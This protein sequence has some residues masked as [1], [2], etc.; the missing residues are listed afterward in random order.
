VAGYG[1][2]TAVFLVT[3]GRVG[4]HFGRRRVFAAGLA[5]FVVT[6]AA[7]GL[8]PGPG[9]LVAARLAQGLSAALMS[10]N[11]LSILGVVY[12]GAARV[13]AISVYGMV[14]GLA[15]VSGQLLG[16]LLLSADPAGLGWRVVFW[17]NLPVGLAAL[18]AVR[19]VPES[20]ADRSTRVDLAGVVL[21]TLALLAVLLPL[22]Q[23]R[24]LG[25]PPWSWGCLGA[26]P[27]LLW[28]FARY[29][30]RLAGRGGAPLLDPGVFASASLRAGLG[31]QLVFWCQQ[32]ACY[33]FLA[34][35]LQQ[36]R[37]EGA[38]ESGAVFTVLAA[39]Y[40]VT[41]LR[42][43]SLTIRFGRRVILIGSLVAAA[44][45]FLLLGAVGQAGTGGPVALLFPGLFLVGAGQGL[46]ITP[47]TTTV[48]SHVG[49]QTAGSV[50]GTL[51]T[52]QQAGNALGVAVVGVV[53]FGAA[54]HGY[55]SSFGRSVLAM[56]LLLLAVA[57]LTRLLPRG[58]VP[59]RQAGPSQAGMTRES[60]A[61]GGAG[62]S[63]DR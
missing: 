18:A 37:G 9:I 6:S 41:S 8:A 60:P 27:V 31:T 43:P 33:L 10:P 17:I 35:Y 40:L 58:A 48:L 38:L 19:L 36:G 63:G 44:G 52:M 59:V 12:T 30:R 5:L 22:V 25:W 26:S 53:F 20:R 39:G 29:E 23:G 51:S 13:R 57:A 16:G 32:A 4:D 28:A 62:V 47:L 7:C 2:T 56:G 46:C 54:G 50:S 34:L 42:A 24:Q 21:V 49:P 55:A 11:I 61:P 45:D 15:A 3:G 1:L 14:M